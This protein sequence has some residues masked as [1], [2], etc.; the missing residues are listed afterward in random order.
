MGHQRHVLRRHPHFRAKA[1][2]ATP[3]AKPAALAPLLIIEGDAGSRER[4]TLSLQASAGNRA[5][6][7]SLRDIATGASLDGALR[8]V[9]SP[10]STAAPA[11][12][13]GMQIAGEATGMRAAGVTTL[14]APGAPD[15]VIG[16]PLRQS[17]GRWQARVNATTVSPD[18]P[19]SLYPGIGVHEE[20]A[21]ATGM[22][23]HRHVTSA[24]SDEIKRG[25]EEHLLDLEWARHLAYDQVGDAINRVAASG[26]VTG[27]T[28]D[29]ARRVALFSVRSAVP[30]QARWPDGADPI[31]HWRRTYGRLV[32][33]T[34]ERDSPNRWH[35]MSTEIVMDPQAKQQLG[36]PEADELRRYI[37]GTT[38]VGQHP[39]APLVEG[40]Y[41]SQTVEP[42]GQP[43]GQAGSTS[44]EIPAD[45]LGPAGDYEYK[46]NR[47]AYAIRTTRRSA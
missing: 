45:A 39:S 15:V 26:P 28:S 14:P 29:E 16:Q 10:A 35:N 23:V 31:M 18:A 20:Q 34:R 4:A 32:A 38:Q 17:D 22:A 46:P 1:S 13:G 2:L 12:G 36:V 19:T 25:E 44:Q 5:V 9:G 41:A 37:A 24:A 42:L 27:A 11:P 8:V 47:E 33:V 40:R 3:S 7:S 43:P 6:A 21:T 30:A